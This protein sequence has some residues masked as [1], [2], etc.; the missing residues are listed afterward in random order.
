VKREAGRRLAVLGHPVSHSLSPKIFGF[1]AKEI[2]RNVS[3]DRLDIQPEKL[4]SIF[5]PDS[6]KFHGFN[7]TLPHKEKVIKYLD[8][9]SPEAR[10]LA[11]VNVVKFQGK[12]ALGFNTDTDGIRATFEEQKFSLAGKDVVL[13]G[14]GGAARAVAFVLGEGK[15]KTVWILNRNP[16]R[17]KVLVKK[18]GKLFPRTSFQVLSSLKILESL[19]IS[20]VVQS[21]PHGMQ[22]IVDDSPKHSPAISLGKIPRLSKKALAFD[23]VY[24]PALTPFLKQASKQR[25]HSVGGLDM[26]IWQ[27]I[28]SWEIWFKSGKKLPRSQ[29]TELKRRLS[30]YLRKELKK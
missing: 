28:A 7:I 16:A 2:G 26:L 17:A 10:A 25:I 27:A 11:A 22:G 6:E 30:S 3:Y 14:A 29:R 19:E 8:K 24:R 9:L 20:L 21:T 1:I 12:K 15:A 23:L 5:L 18:F 4:K 13:F